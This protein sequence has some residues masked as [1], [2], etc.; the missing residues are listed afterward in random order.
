MVHENASLFNPGV[1][2]EGTPLPPVVQT[3]AASNPTFE[4]CFENS[5]GPLPTLT[6]PAPSP[7][8]ETTTPAISEYSTQ[9]ASLNSYKYSKP[10]IYVKN[11]YPP[12]NCP[13][14]EL[15]RGTAL[16]LG[17]KGRPCYYSEYVNSLLGIKSK[18]RKKKVTK[19]VVLNACTL[20]NGKMKLLTV[21]F[22]NA[23]VTA[24]IDTGSPH[25]LLSAEAYGKLS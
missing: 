13:Q 5:P 11:N 20:R 23:S 17:S 2:I 12:L 9:P 25:C 6:S 16:L 21:N 19:T 1:T 3:V 24:L 7:E 18:A 4:T 22:P 15:L 10:R 8:H 14:T